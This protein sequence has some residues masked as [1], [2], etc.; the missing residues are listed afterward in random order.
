MSFFTKSKK[1]QHL[2]IGFF[3]ATRN[4]AWTEDTEEINQTE[5]D[6]V[7]LLKCWTYHSLVNKDVNPRDHIEN[8]K[9]SR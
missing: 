4:G 6:I 3:D 2:N 1:G 9:N 7:Y 8:E 5:S